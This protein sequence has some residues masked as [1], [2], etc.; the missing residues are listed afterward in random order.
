[1][2]VVTDRKI[3]KVRKIKLFMLEE[4]I[5]GD[6]RLLRTSLLILRSFFPSEADAREVPRLEVEEPMLERTLQENNDK[7]GLPKQ[8][9]IPTY[10]E[11]KQ[12]FEED[13]IDKDLLKKVKNLY[14]NHKKGLESLTEKQ[15]RDLDRFLNALNNDDSPFAESIKE[16]AEKRY[17]FLRGNKHRGYEINDA[18]VLYLEHF[19]YE[20][21]VREGGFNQ[22]YFDLLKEDNARE[23]K[24]E[25]PK[26]YKPSEIIPNYEE[27]ERL[28]DSDYEN[29]KTLDKLKFLHRNYKTG[30]EQLS[31]EQTS[32]I[33]KL[34]KGLNKGTG[35]L[36][37]IIKGSL[38]NQYPFLRRN[39]RVKEYGIEDA[40]IIYLGLE[41]EKKYDV[42]KEND[43]FNIFD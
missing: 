43:E 6:G 9:V 4:R 18:L 42:S 22:A 25:K 41:A 20:R 5:F 1:M 17:G 24:E 37:G 26:T 7:T 33:K 3:Y 12:S 13:N 28:F 16:S 29:K 34:Q 21:F 32:E 35:F 30:L 10:E 40:L 31:E 38:Q 8:E 23:R 15:R 36:D 39:G 27:F 14:E 11:Y 2:V 19:N